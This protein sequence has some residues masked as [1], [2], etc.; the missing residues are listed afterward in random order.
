M[1][2]SDPRVV[3][4]QTD[5]RSNLLDGSAEASGPRRQRDLVRDIEYWKHEALEAKRK[6][7]ALEARNALLE[8][9]LVALATRQVEA[10][11]GQSSPVHSRPAKE[12]G[13]FCLLRHRGLTDVH[14]SPREIAGRL[15]DISRLDRSSILAIGRNRS[16]LLVELA[17]VGLTT[18]FRDALRD[19]GA[20][21][22]QVPPEEEMSVRPDIRVRFD[23]YKRRHVPSEQ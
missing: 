16:G 12:P 20:W 8:R 3:F 10:S 6:V 4:G 23:T 15:A 13:G 5:V 14:I 1:R 9:G 21:A 7:D 18:L 2:L 17:T 19:H 11:P 22:W